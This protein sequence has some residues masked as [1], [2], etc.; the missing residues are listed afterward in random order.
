MN[1]IQAAGLVPMLGRRD[2]NAV[3]CADLTAV[4]S[5]VTRFIA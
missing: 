4:S 5:T 1:Q 2:G 3:R